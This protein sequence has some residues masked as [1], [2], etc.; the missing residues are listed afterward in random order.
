M[1]VTC[2][3]K[4]ARAPCKIR[5]TRVSPRALPRTCRASSRASPIIF[6]YPRRRRNDEIPVLTKHVC[7]LIR[8]NTVASRRAETSTSFVRMRVVCFRIFSTVK[9]TCAD[10]TAARIN[11]SRLNAGRA[12]IERKGFRDKATLSIVQSQSGIC[13]FDAPAEMS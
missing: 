4:A 10:R 3:T 9:R 12:K 7:I 8:R 1:L 2:S 5:T 11:Q 13:I 6:S